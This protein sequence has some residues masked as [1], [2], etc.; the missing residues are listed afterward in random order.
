MQGGL[1]DNTMNGVLGTVTTD[2][3]TQAPVAGDPSRFRLEGR[4]YCTQPA[5]AVGGDGAALGMDEATYAAVRDAHDRI[6]NYLQT[7]VAVDVVNTAAAAN[8]FQANVEVAVDE[9]E[10]LQATGADARAAA[11]KS[12]A[13]TRADFVTPRPSCMPNA[14]R[15]S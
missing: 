1:T 11:A 12:T 15:M 7:F 8:T 3:V 5:R 6:K 2:A 14:P 13:M 10:L 9:F 4:G